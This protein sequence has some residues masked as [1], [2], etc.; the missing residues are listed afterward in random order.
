MQSLSHTQIASD[1]AT[2]NIRDSFYLLRS[3][4]G[5]ECPVYPCQEIGNERNNFRKAC[6]LRILYISMNILYRVYKFM[7]ESGQ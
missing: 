5:Y 3:T 7:G 4:N 6:N 2:V 1:P